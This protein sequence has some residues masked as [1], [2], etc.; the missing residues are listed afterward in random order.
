MNKNEF[1]D[2]FTEQFDEIDPSVVSM[3]TEFKQL[4]GWSSMVALMLI[5]MVDEKYGKK[6]TG[7]DIKEARTVSDLFEVIQN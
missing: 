3:E 4:D 1:L 2:Y 6:L 5:A 7:K